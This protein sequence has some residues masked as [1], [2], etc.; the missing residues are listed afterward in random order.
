M[1]LVC[2]D[3]ETY[4]DTE[5]SLSK[6]TT[7][8]YVRDERFLAHGVGVK[9]DSSSPVWVPRRLIPGVFARIPWNECAVL[10]QNTIF[11]GAILSWHYGVNPKLWL[12]TMSMFRALHPEERASLGSMSK[13]LG[14]GTKG[15]ELVVSKGKRTLNE[16]EEKA[17]S[18]YCAT[19][20]DSDINLTLRAFNTLKKGFP[21]DE[22]QLIDANIR[23]FTE[24]VLLLNE[25]LLQEAYDE[26]VEAK[27]LLLE[28]VSA[29]K[30]T[31]ASNDKFAALLWSL[32]IDPPKK[33][34]PAKLKKNPEIELYLEEPPVGLIPKLN[35]KALAE[36]HDTATQP[37]PCEVFTYAFGKSDEEFKKLAESEN[38]DT[39]ALIAARM[40]TKSTLKETRALTFLKIAR[41]GRTLPVPYNF[42]GGHTGRFSGKD[43]NLQNLTRGS[44]LRLAI[45][46][47]PGH[48]L[49]VAD[50]NAIEART[51]AYL[52]GQTD[53]VEAFRRGEDVYSSMATQIYGRK[54][55]RNKEED[56]IEG[57]TGKAVIL[58][59]GYS[60]SWRKFQAMIRIGMLG[61]KGFLF[62]EKVA[63][64]LG[65]NIQAFE[66]KYRKSVLET[67][68][69]GM[70]YGTHLVHCACAC[71]IVK[72]FRDQSSKVVDFWG[73]CQNALADMMVGKSRTVGATELLVTE[74]NATRLPNGMKLLYHDL[75]AEQKGR[76]LEYTKQGKKCRERVYG[77]LCAENYTQAVARIIMTDAWRQCRKE[78]L[79]V[80]LT[81][82]DELIIC[83]PEARAEKEHKRLCEI[84]STSPV[85]APDLPMRA[86]GGY[87]RNYSK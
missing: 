86:K 9:I 7:E 12:D 68:P 85:W 26:E 24:P 63:F 78:G 67:L 25:Q 10:C 42:Y 74:K 72:R 23:L 70:D 60:M 87:A 38:P 76:R 71:S 83:S 79:R 48:V 28:K 57:F 64:G 54:I 51:V 43:Y 14:I 33:I 73:D 15:S 77:G 75:Q 1:H 46:A 58:G 11:D 32:G 59:C 41:A 84:M 80:V 18:G 29:D 31:L 19:N 8:A 21:A 82:H 66:A 50:F 56:F 69:D 81:T 22:I 3:F 16:Y 39:A 2:L 4:Y 6:M 55:D 53:M 27:R 44:K 65:I 62:D 61:M 37:H 17:L 40:G 20:R 35:K 13:V 45:E 49:G 5:Y 36:Y 47:P 34:S 52:A 30:D